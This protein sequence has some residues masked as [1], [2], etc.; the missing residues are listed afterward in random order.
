[1]L[2]QIVKVKNEED[3]I[4][5]ET[6]SLSDYEGA[7]GEVALT[8]SFVM[9]VLRKIMGKTLTVIDAS[10][11]DK[12]QN[13]A[14]KDLIRGIISDEMSFAADMAFDQEKLMEMA[15]QTVF[16]DAVSIEEALGVK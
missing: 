3:V 4:S 10:I 14:I 15:D 9:D 7:D 16:G 8:H 13:K 2:K 5:Y 6:L 12:Q 11:S 1:M